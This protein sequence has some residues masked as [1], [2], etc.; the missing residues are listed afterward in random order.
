MNFEFQ[1]DWKF[2]VDLRKTYLASKLKIVKSHGYEAYNS[3]EV[4]KKSKEEAKADVDMEKQDEP[5]AQV[6]LV[7]HVNNTF[8]SIFSNVE[9]YIKGQQ[10][11][12]SNWFFAHK[13]F[14]S[15][16]FNRAMSENNGVLHRQRY[17]YE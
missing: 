2:Y 4:K 11:Y 1:T 15:N 14:S 6:P 12:K 5:E 3:K 8:H 10:I 7:T 16:F 17:D 13:S 9:V